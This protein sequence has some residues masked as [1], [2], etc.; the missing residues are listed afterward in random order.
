[1][2]RLIAEPPLPASVLFKEEEDISK[3]KVGFWFKIKNP[4][5]HRPIVPLPIAILEGL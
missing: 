5:Y 1:M 2:A 3:E 4:K